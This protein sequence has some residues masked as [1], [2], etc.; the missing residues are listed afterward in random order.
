MRIYLFTLDPSTRVPNCGPA[1]TD[2]QPSTVAVTHFFISTL[3]KYMFGIALLNS[4]GVIEKYKASHAKCIVPHC[5]EEIAFN[6]KT[7]HA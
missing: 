3:D 6:H 7:I 2:S 1:S 4:R 5:Q